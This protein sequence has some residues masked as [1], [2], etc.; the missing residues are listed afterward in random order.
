MKSIEKI[1]CIREYSGIDN[2]CYNIYVSDITINN[3]EIVSY[4]MKATKPYVFNNNDL[5]EKMITLLRSEYINHKAESYNI[6]TNLYI[7]ENMINNIY[8][9]NYNRKINYNDL[10]FVFYYD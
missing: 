9:L 10:T 3:G 8:V 5:V 2:R 6:D 4:K 7:S 1:I